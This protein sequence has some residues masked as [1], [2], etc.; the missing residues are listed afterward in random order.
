VQ[1]VGGRWQVSVRPRIT[2]RYEVQLAGATAARV[3]RVMPILLVRHSR[4]TVTA[5]LAPL[6]QLAGKTLFLFRLT[7]QSWRNVGHTRTGRDGIGRFV[8]LSAGRYYVGYPGG[9][10]Y[11]GTASAPFGVGS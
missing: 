6:P 11:W 7:A 10:Q 3:V 4:T 2:T 1:P 9:G 8:R 5:S